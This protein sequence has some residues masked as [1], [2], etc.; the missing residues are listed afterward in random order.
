[1]QTSGVGFFLCFVLR[2]GFFVGLFVY[3]FVKPLH[4][5]K[6]HSEKISLFIANLLL[7]YKCPLVSLDNPL[8]E[9]RNEISKSWAYYDLILP[10]IQLYQS[11]LAPN[12]HF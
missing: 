4:N 3:L 7:G 6:L 1:M 8:P 10:Q 5:N 2:W 9:R 11:L 12:A